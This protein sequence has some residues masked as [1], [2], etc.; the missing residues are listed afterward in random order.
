[1]QGLY[2]VN[3][4]DFLLNNEKFLFYMYSPESKGNWYVKRELDYL[5]ILRNQLWWLR[6]SFRQVP[7]RALDHLE[8]RSRG[9]I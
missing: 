5:S 9:K 2:V 8:N 1:M 3:F 4:L 7:Y 6:F